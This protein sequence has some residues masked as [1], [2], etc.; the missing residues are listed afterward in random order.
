MA[1]GRFVVINIGT[2]VSND[3][4]IIN[5]DII[6]MMENL[7]FAFKRRLFGLNQKVLRDYG[8]AALPNPWISSDSGAVTRPSVQS[9]I[10]QFNRISI[11]NSR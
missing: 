8:S 3:D 5:A 2:S 6:K 1:S 9:N 11:H 10:I 4:E 7:N